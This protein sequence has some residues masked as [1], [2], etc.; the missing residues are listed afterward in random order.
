MQTTSGTFL[1]QLLPYH[2]ET[3]RLSV[4]ATIAFRTLISKLLRNCH[5]NF[6]ATPAMTRSRRITADT[7][8]PQSTN[9]QCFAKFA[10]NQA[11]PKATQSPEEEAPF[12]KRGVQDGRPA[13]SCPTGSP[14]NGKYHLVAFFP[15]FPE[16]TRCVVSKSARRALGSGKAGSRPAPMRPCKGLTG[17]GN[18]P[19]ATTAPG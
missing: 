5:F 1:A 14:P 19:G 17:A 6:L 9:S 8:V 4:R 3:R 15:A 12:T 10:P 18:Y 16:P 2:T 13:S 7:Q 11:N